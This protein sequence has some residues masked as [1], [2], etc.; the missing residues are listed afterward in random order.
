MRPQAT[1]WLLDLAACDDAALARGLESLGASVQQRF[2]RFRR[3][4]RQRQFLAGRLLLRR[5]LADASGAD[6]TQIQF[7]ERPGLPPLASMPGAQP[8][9]SI[10]H[11]GRWVACV[12]SMSAPLG[13]DVELQ[14]RQR[15]FSAL[16]EHSFDA[17]TAQRIAALPPTQRALPFYREWCRLE[18][19]YKLGQPAQYWQYPAHAQL[20][21]AVASSVEFELHLRAA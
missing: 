13:L 4:E 1:L 12:V 18:A 20:A 8:Y 9:F 5:A 6:G 15:D 14:S 16:A 7:F 2:R 19:A 10:S 3:E 21:I 11:A 17:A